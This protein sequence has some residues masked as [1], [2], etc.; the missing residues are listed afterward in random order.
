MS[1]TQYRPLTYFDNDV[2]NLGNLQRAIEASTLP[3]CAGCG[4]SGDGVNMVFVSV[5]TAPEIVTLD[6]IVATVETSPSITLTFIAPSKVVDEPAALT[7]QWT[8]LGGVRTSVGFFL[9]DANTAVGRIVGDCKSE[10]VGAKLRLVKSNDDTPISAEFLI[11]DTSGSWA[12]FEFQT[13]AP[14][15]LAS[16]VYKLQGNV[17]TATS[18]EVR[19]ASLSLLQIGG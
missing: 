17:G 9:T 10:G 1:D 16:Q 13:N 3:E 14:P 2:C 6:G 12:A 19:F 15:D 11:P 4:F 7:S 18:A 8:D 5:L